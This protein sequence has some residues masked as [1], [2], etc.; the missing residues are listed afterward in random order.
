MI[1]A[2]V[3]I[4]NATW[5]G[6]DAQVVE[7]DDQAAKPRQFELVPLPSKRLKYANGVEA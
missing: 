3:V 4:G 2:S 5:N 7:V 1:V 6:L